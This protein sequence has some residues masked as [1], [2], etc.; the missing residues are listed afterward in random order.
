MPTSVYVALSA[1]AL[2]SCK[3]TT[4]VT[5]DLLLREPRKTQTA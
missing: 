3:P 2:S 5:R 1:D 4:D